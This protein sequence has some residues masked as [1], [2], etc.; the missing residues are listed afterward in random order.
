MMQVGIAALFASVA[1]SQTAEETTSLRVPTRTRFSL[2]SSVLETRCGTLDCHGGAERN[3][4][5][6]GVFG[7]REN[8]LDTTGG[9]DTTE[10]EI[11][12]N[13]ASLSGIEP[14]VLSR[15]VA[16]RGTAPERWIVIAKG[17]DLQEHEGGARLIQGEPADD[18]V[19]SWL[20]GEVDGDLC[21][22]DEFSAPRDAAP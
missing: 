9:V 2:V 14:E 17:R 12:A 5:L 19:V 4:R 6:Y 7:L 8:G 15:V 22:A 16:E 10:R 3:L 13:F 20:S 11:E 18:C 1:C 21:I